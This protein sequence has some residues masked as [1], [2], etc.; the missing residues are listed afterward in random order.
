M[1]VDLLAVGGGFAGLAAANRA[2]E[3]GLSAA[4][5][6]RGA[7]PDYMCN[8]RV[9][10]GA[11]HCAMQDAATPPEALYRRILDMTGGAARPDLAR[12]FADNA[13]RTL[14]WIEGA[15]GRFD[16][17]PGRS[18]GLPMMAPPR[19]MRAGLDWKASGPHRLLDA[20]TRRLER[21]GGALHRGVEARSLIL[22]GG[23]CA[24]C[25]VE[26]PDGPVEIEARA[27]VLADGG[28]QADLDRL[29]RCI[30]ARPERIVQRNVRTGR[31]D[32]ARM[33]EH[34]GAALVGL[35]RFYGHVLSRDAIADDRLWPYPQLDVVCASAIAVDPACRRF[36]DE[37]LGGI[38]LAN[39]IA[40]LDDPLGATAVF[41]AA[42]WESAREAD[43]VPPNPSLVE[44]G[45][46][47]H[48]AATI[49]DLAGRAAL[50]AAA[51]EAAVRAFNAA[52]RSG[53]LDRLDPP[54]SDGGFAPRP[55]ETPPF[56]AAPLA[57]GITVT[58][59]GVAIDGGARA[60]RADGAPVPGLYAAGSTAGGMEGGPQAGYVG[61]L[62]KAF[63]LGL[64][65]AESAAAEIRPRRARTGE[66][67]G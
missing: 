16:R 14:A 40:G 63:L 17:R 61:G 36:A 51:L 6:E 4:V 30:S 18:Y 59:G 3:L 50:E 62:I 21:A 13:R 24:G 9:S 46:T 38:H 41:D 49:E 58:M 8:S 52:V 39:A 55:I 22:R 64:V 31:G 25:A 32:G 35:D 57:A 27:V 47:L 43:I 19:E 10:T 20:L 54:R 67:G 45:G 48:A 44:A 65:A 56:H 34:A 42:V 15:G 7:A 29:G 28:F 33:A 5:V 11:F 37:G 60:L 26:G 1:K 66:D 53:R 2:A 12:C 23:A